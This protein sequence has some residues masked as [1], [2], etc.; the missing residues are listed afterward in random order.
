MIVSDNK[1]LDN[2]SFDDDPRVIF[3][4]ITMLKTFV[5]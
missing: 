2:S 3:D 5:V 4:F 1:T